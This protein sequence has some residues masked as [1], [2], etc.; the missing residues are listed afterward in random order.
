MRSR[1]HARRAR[2]R[3]R[4]AD[5]SRVATTGT[6]RDTAA[7]A[8]SAAPATRSRSGQAGERG[9]LGADDEDERDRPARPDGRVLAGPLGALRVASEQGVGRVGQAVE[10]ERARRER[11]H[12]NGRDR[13]E[14]R[15]AGRPSEQHQRD[16]RPRRPTAAPTTPNAA[17][18]RSIGDDRPDRDRASAARWRARERRPRSR[19]PGRQT[20]ERRVDAE[21]GPDPGRRRASRRA[22]R[23]RRPD[24]SSRTTT[25]GKKCAASARSWST[26][27]TVVPSRRLSSTSSSMTSTWWRMSRWAVGS[28]RTR[29]GAAWATASAMN[30]SCRS[31]IDSSRTSRPRRARDADP[32][33]GAVDG[34]EVGSG[35]GPVNGGSCGSRP[36]ATTSSTGIA[37]GRS[38]SSGTTAIVRASGLAV[39]ALD[40]LAAQPDRPGP[41][42]EHAGQRAEQRRL[43]GAVRARRGRPARRAGRAG[44]RAVEDASASP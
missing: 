21:D 5:S 15:L 27:T 23:R 32:L 31:P 37:N 39:D 41:R 38:A 4:D 35:A 13:A 28:S 42:R 6:T 18:P 19:R 1:N 9:G 44:R 29:I 25:R 34:G 36:S 43:A 26:A 17:A 11:H 30:T 2:P 24:R 16:R 40:R 14:P 3:R 20:H 22:A 7:T 12:G 10:V 8:T 33:D